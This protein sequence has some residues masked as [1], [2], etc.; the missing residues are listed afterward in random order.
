MENQRAVVLLSGGLDSAIAVAY[1]QTR[2]YEIAGSVFVNRGQSNYK[3]ELTAAVAVAELLKIPIYISKF[4][5]PDLDTLVTEEARK[6]FGIPAR[7]LI[8]GTLA[9]PYIQALNCDHLV[10]GNIASDIFPDSNLAFREKFS[11]VV[12]HVLDR[13]IKVTA[14]LADWENWDKTGEILFASKNNLEILFSLTWTCWGGGKFP[15]RKCKAC[16]GRKEGFAKA[17]LADPTIYEG[18]HS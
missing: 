12:S 5:I 18:A 4:S 2:N 11:S 10:L 8:M 17:D 6:K 16:L 3:K 13:Q 15:C 7:N 14:P 1:L 9:L